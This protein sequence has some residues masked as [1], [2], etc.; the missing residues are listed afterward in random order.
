MCVEFGKGRGKKGEMEG[1]G[2]GGRDKG[3][4]RRREGEEWSERRD[5]TRKWR[6]PKVC[7]F[8]RRSFELS[9]DREGS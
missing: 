7:M 4:G 2:E 3:R 8:E 5:G 6:E 1:E 9:A